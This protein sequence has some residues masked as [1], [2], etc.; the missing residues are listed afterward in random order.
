MA[1]KVVIVGCGIVGAMTAYE[2]SQVPGLDL[3]VLEQHYPAEGST[4]AALGVLMGLISHKVKGRTWRLR[5]D[6]TQRYP[7]LM[8]ELMALTGQPISFNTQGILS[9]CFD[10]DKL[11]KWDALKAIRA[12]QGWPLEIWSPEQV[13][14]HCPHLNISH[15]T[16]GIYSPQDGQVDPTA[17]TNALVTAAQQNGVEFRMGVEV[18]G[19]NCDRT[20]KAQLTTTAADCSPDWVVLSGG[21]GTHALMR[22]SPEPVPLIPVFGQAVR[23]EL[24]QPLGNR[25]FQPVING[26]DV[27]LVPHGSGQYSLGATVEFPAVPETASLETFQPDPNLFEQ[28]Q[29]TAMDYCPSLAQAKTLRTWHNLRP[30]PQGQPAPVIQPLSGFQNVTLATG[31]YRNGVLLAPATAMSVKAQILEGLGLE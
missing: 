6:S 19:V 20:G 24:P 7:A 31:H 16:A 30:R 25:D 12:E 14:E 18:T 5:R 17:L 21:I 22:Q 9:L 11:P 8:D 10:P 27:H 15:L 26:H 3:L 2:L 1:K 4:G 29:Q 28:M 23:V 13:V